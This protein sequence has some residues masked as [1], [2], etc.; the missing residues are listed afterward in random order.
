MMRRGNGMASHY[1]P[2]EAAPTV[3]MTP[4]TDDLNLAACDAAVCKQALML[5]LH[6]VLVG[7]ATGG[8]GTARVQGSKGLS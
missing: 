3:L 2:S 7:P 1:K 8:G 4:F 6:K 5:D